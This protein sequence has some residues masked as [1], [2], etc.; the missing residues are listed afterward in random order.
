MLNKPESGLLNLQVGL[1]KSNSVTR[2]KAMAI[3]NS[4]NSKV[5]AQ[6]DQLFKGRFVEHLG[7]T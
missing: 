7:L 1:K 6:H 5:E 2:I 4:V 3:A